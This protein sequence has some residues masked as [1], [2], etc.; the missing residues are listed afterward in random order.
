MGYPIA[1]H[2]I[3]GLALLTRSDAA[4]DVEILVLRHQL[5]VLQRQVGAP[6]VDM[7]GPGDH[8]GADV[9]AAAGPSSACASRRGRSWGGIGVWAPGGG[10]WVSKT[11]VGL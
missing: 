11:A 7:G 3:G 6:A 8:R 5:A 4:K 10:L 9:A 2:L 1:R